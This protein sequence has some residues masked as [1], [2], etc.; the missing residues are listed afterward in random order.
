MQEC[1][2]ACPGMVRSEGSCQETHAE[3]QICVE[4]RESEFSISAAASWMLDFGVVVVLP[5]V[6][7]AGVALEGDS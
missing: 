4:D 1:M 6:A 2:L 3:A 7:V 5:M